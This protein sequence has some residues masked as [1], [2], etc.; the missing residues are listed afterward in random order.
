MTV[1]D[2]KQREGGKNA[3]QPKFMLEIQIL[4]PLGEDVGK[5]LKLINQIPQIPPKPK[6]F[7]TFGADSSPPMQ[8]LV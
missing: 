3:F 6:H 1:L 8:L 7:C 5:G 4:H 2:L